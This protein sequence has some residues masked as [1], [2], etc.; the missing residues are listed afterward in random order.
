M[1]KLI[2]G[3]VGSP[4]REGLTNRLVGRTLEGAA[5]GGAQIQKLFLYDYEIRPYSE[6]HDECPD[7]LSSL[8][9]QAEAIVLGAPVYY[10]DINGLTKDFM[11]T[12]RISNANGKYALGISVAGGS[13]KGLVSGV[14]TLYHF[15]YHRQLRG[16]DPTPVSRFN[17]E[18]ALQSLY[19]S[20]HRLAEFSRAKTPFRDLAEV[21]EHHQ[22]LPYMGY[23]LLDEMLLLAEQLRKAVENPGAA[24]SDY[25]K[26][27]ALAKQGRRQEAVVYAVKAYTTLYY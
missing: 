20:G 9:E 10:G 21:I 7:A 6:E 18:E 24:R 5:V 26:A 8:C 27:Q 14:Q 16:V 3:I 4:R 15:F 23:D 25:E 13:G 12:V 1:I 2:L 11:D 17:L 19:A 22:G